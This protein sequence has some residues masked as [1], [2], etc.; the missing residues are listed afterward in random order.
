ML[1]A[2]QTIE[3]PALHLAVHMSMIL[4]LRE[5]EILGLQPS[6]LDFDAADGRGTISVNKALQRADKVALSKIDPTQIYHTFPDRRE[7]SKSSL[8][9][10][11]TKTKKSN[12]IL[13]MTKPLKEELLAWLEKMK[14]DEQNAPEKYSNCGQLFRLPDGLPI[15][16]DVLT[17]WYRMWRAE[18]PEFE[19]IVFHGLRHPYVKHTTKIFSLRLMDFQA[20]AYPDARRKTR[21]ACQLHRGGQSQSPVRPLCN[22]KQFS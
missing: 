18:H 16:P 11:R 10:K 4:S 6:D 8:I 15:A 13:Y 22:R 19:K 2:L 3:N 14:Q 7:G 17:K 12:R 9:L 5:G 20:Q 1:A 21:G